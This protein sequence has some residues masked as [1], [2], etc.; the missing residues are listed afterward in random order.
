MPNDIN[1]K[2]ILKDGIEICSSGT[3]GT[4]KTIFQSPEKLEAANRAAVAAQRITENSRVYTVCK[5]NHAGGLLA[6]TL[7]AI[8]VGASVDI[9]DFNAYTWVSK[10][11]D[12]TH[13]HLTPNHARAIMLTKGFKDLN[14]KGIFIT[15]GADPVTWDIIE[16]FVEKGCTFMTNWGMTEIGPVAINS[17]FERTSDIE[18]IKSKCPTD[19]TI[20]GDTSYAIYR[21][22]QDNVLEVKGDICVY[23]DWY[24]TNDIVEMVDGILFYKGRL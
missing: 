13:S 2:Q 3:T 22:N 18:Q 14:L 16:A 1:F 17:T 23:D 11:N 12:Y 20:L 19:A 8:S 4:P 6:Q 15:C 9:E 24:T 21:I 10:I 5:M 7:P